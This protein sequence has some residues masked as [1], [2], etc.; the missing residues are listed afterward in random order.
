MDPTRILELAPPELAAYF[1]RL[2]KD[3]ADAEESL[4]A[5]LFAAIERESLPPSVISVWL[6]IARSP[7]GLLQALTQEFSVSIR[8]FAIKRFFKL[9][10][11]K[12]WLETWDGVGGTPG[13][14]TLL[15]DFSVLEVNMC[16]VR[17][18]R[19]QT[20]H[21]RTE[22][23]AKVTELLQ[24]LL[25]YLYPD[26]PSQTSDERLFKGKYQLL[27]PRCSLVFVDG[28]LRNGGPLLSDTV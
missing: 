22:K 27:L 19:W 15:K 2:L 4:T 13:L 3:H 1:R 28:I 21:D 10:R 17:F 20:A 9:L 18:S 26:A 6:S 7:S 5:S 11:R 25:P 24:G 14:L 16:L 8:Q 23:Q 12:Q